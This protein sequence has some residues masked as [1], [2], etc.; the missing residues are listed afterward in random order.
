MEIN[1]S[2]DLENAIALLSLKNKSQNSA[3]KNQFADAVDSLKPARLLKAA[4][5]NNLADNPGVAKVA[6]GTIVAV[7][8]GGLSKKLIVGKSGNIFRRI[9]GTVV[10]LAVARSVLGNSA[11]I[12]SKGIQLL[13][14]IAK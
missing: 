4:A 13:R 14:K 12:A 10:E 1:N 9:I 11:F 3:L 5:V 8:A 6:I 2:I 7:E